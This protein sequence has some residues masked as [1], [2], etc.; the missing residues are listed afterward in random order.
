MKLYHSN[1]DSTRLLIFFAGFYTDENCFLD[2]DNQKSD[3]LYIYDYSVINFDIFDDFDFSPYLEINLMAY[4]YGVWAAGIIN[5]NKCMP[6]INK[7]C[8]I[9]GTLKPIDDNYGVP[10]NIFDIMLKSLSAD[11]LKTFEE[12]MFK[13][14]EIK[15][16]KRQLENL[17]AELNNIKLLSNMGSNFEFDKI[18]LAKKDRI[19]PYSAQANYWA[20]HKNQLILNTGH[21]P[22]YEFENFDEMLDT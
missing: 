4:S 2:F 20:G 3:V 10:K 7:S 11:S 19:I 6:E 22:F 18:I 16:S 14:V 17:R 9:C 21:F 12:K 8:A 13:G 15:K 1:N 5:N